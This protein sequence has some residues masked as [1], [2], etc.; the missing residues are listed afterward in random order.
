MA[1]LDIQKKQGASWIWWLIGLI[2]LALIIWWLVAGNDNDAQVAEAPGAVAPVA[3]A[4]AAAPAAAAPV[5]DVVIVVTA[6]NP[7]DFVGQH[8]ELRGVHVQSV[9]SDK[10]FWVGPSDTQRLF[11]VR[12]NQTAPFTPPNGA[13]DPGQT[14][15]LFGVVE[16][17]PD[18][19]T[20]QTTEWNLASTDTAALGAERVYIRVDSLTI[21]A[22]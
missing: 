20:P 5:T 15:D 12:T 9:V 17:M 19:L 11:A 1:Q 13:V 16:A 8:V 6:P 2:V 14:V 7:A 10:G 22:P 18:D 3:T 21:A 4:P